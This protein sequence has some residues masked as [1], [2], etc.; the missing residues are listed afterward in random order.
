MGAPLGQIDR[1]ALSDYLEL[2]YVPSPAT[3]WSNVRKVLPGHR[4]RFPGGEAYPFAELPLP[5]TSP[6][7]PSRIAVRARLEEAVKRALRGSQP[8]ALVSSGLESAALVALMTRQAG[9]VRTFAVAVESDEEIEA[10]RRIAHRFRSD[11]HEMRISLRPAEEVP[12]TLAACGEPFADAGLVLL[13][14]ALE[15]I[16]RESSALL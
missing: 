3:M 11:H 14:A 6:K 13:C 4:V 9:R 7:K 15:A 1:G 12:K 10:A 16:S 5:G 2:G 8:A